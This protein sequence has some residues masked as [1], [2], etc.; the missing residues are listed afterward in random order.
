[1]DRTEM[2]AALEAILFTMGDAVDEERLAAALEISVP[3]LTDL[4]K[5]LTEDFA[6]SKHGIMISRLGTKYQMCTKA[7]HYP[8]LIKLCHIP[9]KHVLTDTLLETLSIIAYKQPVTRMEVENIRGVRCDYA[10]NTLIDYH[11]ICELGRLDA[12]GRP[13]LFGTT[14]DFLRSFGVSSLE[15]LP[16]IS[17]DK[18]EQFR[19][20][21]EEEAVIGV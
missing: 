12:P 9:Q 10:I 2:K 3:E 18:M 5:E 19:E 17:T 15:E 11:L 20:E 16:I 14:D 13:I 4:M 6:D 1:M 8:T 21:A 7:E